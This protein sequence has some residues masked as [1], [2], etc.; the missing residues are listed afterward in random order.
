M[1]IWLLFTDQVGCITPTSSAINLIPQGRSISS[2][3]L[4]P[5][6][7]CVV[8]LLDDVGVIMAYKAIIHMRNERLNQ[9]VT[10][11][12]S[13]VACYGQAAEL[14]AEANRLIAPVSALELKPYN[15]LLEVNKVWEVKLNLC[16]P[17]FM[18]VLLWKV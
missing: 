16:L 6:E 2:S 8:N 11:A 13:S 7:P 15:M 12:A 14:T 4:V 3:D 5:N 10:F 17:I 18:I 1:T 9:A